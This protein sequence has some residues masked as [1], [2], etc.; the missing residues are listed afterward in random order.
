M[1]IQPRQHILD[2]WR[3][4]VATSFRDGRWH[5]GGRDH[6]NSISDAEQLLCLL[7]PATEIKSLALDQ[8]DRIADDVQAALRPLGDPVRI[9]RV[10]LDLIGDYFSRYADENG[11]PVF[12]GGSYLRDGPDVAV[13]SE[14]KTTVTEEQSR[15]D[16]V[17]SFSM[18]VTLCLAAL[19]YLSGFE[20]VVVRSDLK[21]KVARLRAQAS[22]R[23]TS[24]MVGLLRSFVVTTVEPGD[25]AGRA[26]VRTI[27]QA[28]A[29][30]H[31]MIRRLQERLRTIRV[32]L[33]DIVD[34][35]VD[36]ELGLENEHLLFECGWS[37]SV[38]R[39]AKAIGFLPA[40]VPL[41]P[42]VADPKPSLYF[43][44]VALDGINDLRSD[45]TRQLGLLDERQSR[46]AEA[47]DLRWRLTQEYWSVLARFGS[48]RWPLMDI[49][50]RT[51]SGESSEYHSLLVSA[52][53]VQH[54]VSRKDSEDIDRAIE[55]FQTLAN[56]GRITERMVD[57][58]PAIRMHTPGV[59]MVLGGSDKLGPLL[60]WRAADY[61]ATLLKRVLQATRLTETIFARDR[62]MKL[63]DATMRHL[64]MRKLKSG[65]STGLWDDPTDVL[66]PGSVGERPAEPRPS[67]YLTE[68]VVEA[69][70]D[71][72]RTFSGKPVSDARLKENAL[73]LLTE[74]D[75][76][77]IQESLESD[78]DDRSVMRDELAEIDA[79]LTRARAII[80]E[81][82]GTAGT[83]ARSALEKIDELARARL[84]ATRSG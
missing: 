45:R 27:N 49:P 76:L 67:W 17:D 12:S 81:R 24:A 2:V 39:D 13:G 53:V 40:D 19:A 57:G 3:G 48:A 21:E 4:L 42:G 56:R 41:K 35:P 26:L 30:E 84:D 5:W 15:L 33:K 1:R 62:L 58:D 80:D 77:L 52:V 14:V 64:L 60:Y 8:P 43:T 36:P 51:T 28:G 22:R 38:V 34:L 83:L 61:S 74:A 70:V 32:S 18:S 71:A 66:P 31:L 50:W 23:L 73:G 78:V 9:P 82:P 6:P 25:E 47:L 69:L 16:V 20:G 29:P 11:E 75:H 7:Y 59:P 44:V 54:L 46:L 63:V 10:L 65:R 79:M 37:W 72:E 55:V 68:R